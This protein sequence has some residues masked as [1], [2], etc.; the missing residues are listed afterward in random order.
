MKK[1]IFKVF[2]KFG[3][4]IGVLMAVPYYFYGGA[5]MP[6]FIKNLGFG[7]G[8]PSSKLPENISNVV[9]DKEVT[10]YQWVDENG[11]KHFGGTPP[12]GIVA[13][14]KQLRPDQ[15]IIQA[16]KIPEEEEQEEKASG[17]KVTNILKKAYTK[18]G[19]ENLI[20]DA[21]GVQ[22]ML[23]KRFE[24]QQKVMDQIK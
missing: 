9:T 20:D 6:D 2:F 16:L 18:E 4:I 14:E 10:V 19:V 17:P 21:K 5:E 11:V 3:I 8:E 7:S 13:E 1:L 22:D 12:V 15:N 24:E 23:D